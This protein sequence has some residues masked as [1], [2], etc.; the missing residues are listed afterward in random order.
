MQR[1]QSVGDG[2]NEDL[3]Q[4]ERIPIEINVVKVFFLTSPH[5]V[6]KRF[7]LLP[8]TSHVTELS[9][10]MDVALKATAVGYEWSGRG[11]CPAAAAAA[12]AFLQ[13]TLGLFFTEEQTCSCKNWG[14]TCSARS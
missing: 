2:L 5:F 9:E 11:Q 14:S 4:T 10:P 13:E 1:T 7:L 8:F 3:A 12:G 6:C